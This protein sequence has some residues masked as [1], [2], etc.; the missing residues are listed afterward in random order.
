MVRFS[1]AGALLLLLSG[2]APTGTAFTC[3]DL[4][5]YSKEQQQR[6]AAQLREHRATIPDV[7]LLVADYHG[8]RKGIMRAC[9]IR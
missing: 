2:C 7:A 6:A 1:V 3:P 5:Q 4:K 8:L 9:H